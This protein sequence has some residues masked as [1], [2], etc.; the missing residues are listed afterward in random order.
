MQPQHRRVR[1]PTVHVPN[2][3]LPKVHLPNVQLPNV[4]LPNVHVPNG[5]VPAVHV[6]IDRDPAVV[7]SVFIDGTGVFGRHAGP[8]CL[9]V[10]DAE[11]ELACRPPHERIG[12]G[13]LD[14]AERSSRDPGDV[15]PTLGIWRHMFVDAC[16]RNGFWFCRGSRR[17]RDPT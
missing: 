11:I 9:D 7:H 5:H 12:D 2:L 8:G 10:L 3:H 15:W 6:P 13:G 16:G 14:L 1:L 4:H 17:H